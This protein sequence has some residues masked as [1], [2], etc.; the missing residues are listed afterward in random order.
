M[1]SSKDQFIEAAIRVFAARGFYGASIAAIVADLPFTKQALLHHFGS[2]EKLYGEVLRHISERLVR[3]LQAAMR[4][5]TDPRAKLE[6]TLVAF[7]R[8]ALTHRDETI[9][10]MRELLDNEPRAAQSKSWYLRGFLEGLSTAVAQTNPARFHGPQAA[11]SLTYQ[12]LGAIQYFVVSE[13]TLRQLLGANAYAAM[14]ARYE[15][16]LRVLIARSVDHR[17]DSAEACAP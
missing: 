13:P 12:L 8:S 16:D 10:L 6:I 11:M 14:R 3:E 2:K 7:Y 1:T 17:A 4:E 9:L 5:A 15:E